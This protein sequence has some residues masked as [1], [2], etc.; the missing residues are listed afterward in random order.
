MAFQ[1]LDLALDLIRS[2][3]PAAQR[4]RSRDAALCRQLRSAASSVALN[5]GEG[6]GRLGQD[7]RHHFSIALG[8]ALEVRTI[9]RVALAWGDV[10]PVLTREPLALLERV[11]AMLWRLAR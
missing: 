1:A 5:L 7:R 8:S 11:L 6:S 2:L 10:D 3:R 9:L 4:L